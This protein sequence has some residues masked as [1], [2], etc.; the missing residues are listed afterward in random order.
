MKHLIAALLTSALAACATPPASP[1]AT[2]A[3]LANPASTY[4]VQQ[5]G[6]L[7][8]RKDAAGNVNGVCVFQDGSQCDEWALFRD[9]RCVA[10]QALKP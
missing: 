5:G 10:P 9:H 8:L 6:R 1:P 7:E 4:C 2:Q 3:G